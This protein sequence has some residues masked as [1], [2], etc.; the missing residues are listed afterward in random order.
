MTTTKTKAL[1]TNVVYNFDVSEE[2]FGITKEEQDELTK[3]T[4]GKTI[5]LDIQEAD[6]IDG[7]YIE[8][9]V[10][11]AISDETGWLVDEVDFTLTN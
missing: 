9:M 11:D 2:S 4:I 6:L 3:T 7:A 5:L 8:E 10:A 1:I